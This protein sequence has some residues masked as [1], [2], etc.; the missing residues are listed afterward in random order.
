MKTIFYKKVGRRYVPV[1]E[2]DSQLMD[3]LPKGDHIVSVYPGGSSYRYKISPAL[4]PMIAA[5]RYAEDAISKA[6]VQASEVRPHR[7]PITEEQRTAWDN[8]VKAF[9]DDRYYVE[10]PSAREITEVGVKAMQL[11]AEKLMQHESVR[12]AYEHF[13]TICELCKEQS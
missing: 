1:S 6:L 5:G 8:L 2:Y 12:L 10:L 3:A 11:E 9:G 4:A 7:K 13:M